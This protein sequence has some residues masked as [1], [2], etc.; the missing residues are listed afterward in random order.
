M[1]YRINAGRKSGSVKAHAVELGVVDDA[2]LTQT[3]V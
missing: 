3:L 1:A 2:T